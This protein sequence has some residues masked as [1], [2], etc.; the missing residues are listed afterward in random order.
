MTD[1][2]I[3]SVLDWDGWIK[4]QKG[5]E[6]FKEAVRLGLKLQMIQVNY[7][8][9][10]LKRKYPLPTIPVCKGREKERV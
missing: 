10:D 7:L 1:K 9:N 8:L 4:Y 3:E 5:S 6:K 2:F